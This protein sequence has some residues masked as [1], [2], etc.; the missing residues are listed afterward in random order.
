MIDSIRRTRDCVNPPV[1][2]V[3]HP[4]RLALIL[5]HTDTGGALNAGRNLLSRIPLA[6]KRHGV[7]KLVVLLAALLPAI[8]GSG[9]GEK[10]EIPPDVIA[11]VGQ[12]TVTLQ[13][14]KRYL[15][16]NAGDEMAQ[17]SPEANSALLD[18]YTEEILLSEY[19]DRNGIQVSTERVAEAVRNDPGSTMVEKRDQIRRERLIS[20]LSRETAEPT[21]DELRTFYQNNPEQFEME[22]R[23]LVRQILV[24]DAT[25]AENIRRELIAGASFE[26]LSARHSAAPNASHGG[27]IGF[28][29][30]G[31]LPQMFEEAIFE[32]K[33]GGISPIVNTDSSWHI[34][35]AEAR[36]PAGV[37]PFE[38]ARELIAARLRVEKLSDRITE[39]VSRARRELPVRI[40]TRRLPFEYSGTSRTSANE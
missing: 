4:M 7:W 14:F 25:L 22:E 2:V 32:L 17:I 13:D 19:A 3:P 5:I 29:G 16:R 36:E 18:Q 27:D 21:E 26:D 34:F 30:R 1:R 11:M 9:C 40:L 28:I 33:P 39:M 23:I 35:K 20:E 24:H 6:S 8:A 37:V 38:R 31:E 10:E 15:E 12:R